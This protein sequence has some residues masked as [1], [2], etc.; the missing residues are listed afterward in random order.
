MAKL[1]LPFYYQSINKVT[2][3]PSSMFWDCLRSL[4]NWT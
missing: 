2:Q 4:S 3:D 1:S